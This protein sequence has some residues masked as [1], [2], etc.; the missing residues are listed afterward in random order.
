MPAASRVGDVVRAEEGE[1]YDIELSTDLLKANQRLAEENKQFLHG[2]D[3]KAIDVMGAIGSGKTSLIEK[4]VKLLK[5][6]YGIAVFKGDLTTTIDADLI[7]RH[8]V[9]VVAINTGKE[10]HLDANL[11]KKALKKL[12]TSKVTLLFIENVGNLICPAEFPL[13]SDRRVVVVS[14]TEGPY[15]VVKHPFIFMEADVAVINKIDLAQAMNVDIQQLAKD[16]KT[17]NPRARV[18]MTNCRS[19]KGID[20]VAEALRLSS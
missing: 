9:E 17:I 14:V 5:N 8:G 15:M 12:D 20:H 6:H 11:V 18:V 1:V 4:L 7:A 19:G 2:K 3:I 16:V 13:G 10:C